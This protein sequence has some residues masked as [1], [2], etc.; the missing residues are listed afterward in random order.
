MRY[1]AVG[2][3]C[4]ECGIDSE[5]IVGFESRALADEWA[6]QNGLVKPHGDFRS[7]GEEVEPRALWT[8]HGGQYR[9]EVHEIPAVVLA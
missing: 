4:L 3:G 9:I 1:V 6:R 8:D 2:I 5:V 7:N